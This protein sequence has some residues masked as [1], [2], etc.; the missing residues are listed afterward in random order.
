MFSSYQPHSMSVGFKRQAL[1]KE[2]SQYTWVE[3][4]HVILL[5]LSVTV[6]SSKAH[7]PLQLHHLPPCPSTH[8]RPHL[9]SQFTRLLL[10]HYHTSVSSP[11]LKP[12]LLYTYDS[13]HSTSHSKNS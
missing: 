7:P 5:F 8:S 13:P 9:S 1:Q 6:G 10:F 2:C 11:L 4:A 3:M 12:S